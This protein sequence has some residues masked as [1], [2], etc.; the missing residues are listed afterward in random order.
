M[1]ESQYQEYKKGK[2]NKQRVDAIDAM[3]KQVKDGT[4]KNNA[5]NY[6]SYTHKPDGRIILNDR[7]LFAK[8]VKKVTKLAERVK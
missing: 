4:F 8:T 2:I 1:I 7:P 6:V 5:G 3:L